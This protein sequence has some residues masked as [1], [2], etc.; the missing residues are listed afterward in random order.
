M[1]DHSV[2]GGRR[3]G[4]LLVVA[5]AVAGVIVLGF[6][7]ASQ[8]PAPPSPPG[9]AVGTIDPSPATSQDRTPSADPT[10]DRPEPEH[11]VVGAAE[12]VPLGASEPVSVSIP[13]IDVRTEVIALGKA[14]DGTLAVPQPGPNLDKAA[15]FEDSPTPGQPGPSVIEGHVATEQRGPSVFFNLGNLRPGDKI[16]VERED[17]KVA[18]FTVDGLR[19]F[20]K[21]TFPTKLVYGGNLSTPTLRLITCSDFDASIGHHTGN[22]V[23]FSHLT[24]VRGA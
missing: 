5:A 2:I 24:R 17:G 9:S 3:G 12:E 10:P 7:L 4:L 14:P 20:D 15:W 11:D 19:D 22:L 1:R 18:V 6:A 16:S 23:V 8:E 21:D 13:A